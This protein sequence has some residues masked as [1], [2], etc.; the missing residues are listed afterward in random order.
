VGSWWLVF[1]DD[2]DQADALAYHDLT[3]DG[4]PISKVFVKTILA[5]NA[6]VS[7]GATHELCEMA[8]THG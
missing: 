3:E 7:V 6:S 2:S 1:L 4:L 8:V 5:D